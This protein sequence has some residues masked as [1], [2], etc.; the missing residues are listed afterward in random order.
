MVWG[1][2]KNICLGLGKRPEMFT[3]TRG[4]FVVVF[5]FYGSVTNDILK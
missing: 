3:V 2:S 1:E 4:L 5:V